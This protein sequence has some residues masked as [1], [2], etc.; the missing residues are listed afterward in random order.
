MIGVYKIQN[1]INE[2]LYYGSSKNIQKRWKTHRSQLNGG[3]H[4][5]FHL[6]RAWIKYGSHNFIF[7]VIEECSLDIL[8]ERE[9]YY[10]DI[11]PKY[12]IGMKSSGGDNLS[13]NPN[14]EEIIKRMTKSTRER[15]DRMTKEEIDKLYSYPM[16]KNPNWKDGK[17]I[18]FCK[19]CGLRISSGAKRCTKHL[20]YERSGE[21]NSFF[22][23]NHSEETKKNLSD[24][25]RGKKPTNMRSV[26]IDDITYESLA[27]AS[28]QKGIPCPTILWRINSKNKKYEDYNYLN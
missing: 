12:N 26:I 10:L 25:R 1:L 24:K 16:E 5:N 23:K 9:Q 20:E 11:N 3:K 21:K 19:I 13:K 2:N 22:G 28:R 27:E 6:Q 18:S 4:G 17:S 15:Y 7:E 8:L 14:R